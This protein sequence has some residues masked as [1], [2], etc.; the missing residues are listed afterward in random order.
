[1]KCV[2]NFVLTYQMITRFMLILK[3]TLNVL[4]VKNSDK[5]F[6]QNVN[7]SFLKIKMYK[8]H[9]FSL[10][11]CIYQTLTIKKTCLQK[12]IAIHVL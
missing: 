8:K 1:M 11:F 2:L 10:Y 6:I 3:K 12:D 9:L 7:K 5:H 4:I